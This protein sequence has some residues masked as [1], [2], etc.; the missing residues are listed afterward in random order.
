MKYILPA[1]IAIGTGLIVLFSYLIPIP[2]LL[3]ARGVLIDWAVI[4]AGLVVL[5]GVANVIIVNARRIQRGETGWGYNLLT[6]GAL[7]FMLAVGV[8]ESYGKTPTLYES[9]SLTGVLYSGV[10]VASQAALAS[11]IVFFLVVAAMRLMRVRPNAWSLLFVV[12]V[13]FM[14][15]SWLPL[16][17]TR[18]LL[19]LRE[20]FL[21]VPV[22]AGARGILLGVALGTVVFGLRVLTGSERPYKD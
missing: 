8:F 21:T 14:L 13:V 9:T 6:V 1:A 17:L 2:D 19:G 11:L 22:M 12:V 10:L 7:V 4:V 15:V 18:P 16:G 5:L 3:I 20:W